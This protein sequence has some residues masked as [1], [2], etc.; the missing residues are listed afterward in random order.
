MK[1]TETFS[2]LF[3]PLGLFDEIL[4]KSREMNWRILPEELNPCVANIDKL[5]WK[6]ISYFTERVLLRPKDVRFICRKKPTMKSLIVQII[7][8][9]A[10]EI[11]DS[12][13]G[14]VGSLENLDLN[15]TL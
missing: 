13:S 8:S 1:S 2:G 5:Q 15:L 14:V 4:T 9:D 6:D 7:S 3:L 10:R 11:S 12:L